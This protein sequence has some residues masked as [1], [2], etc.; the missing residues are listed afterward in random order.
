MY[1]I[2]LKLFCEQILKH[3]NGQSDNLNIMIDEA[4]EGL[5]VIPLMIAVSISCISH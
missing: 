5:D 1:T 3:L 2:R 4:L